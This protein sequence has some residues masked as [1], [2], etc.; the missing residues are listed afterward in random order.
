MAGTRNKQTQLN[1]N[2]YQFELQKQTEWNSPDI[3]QSPAYPC[4]GVNVQR[5]PAKYLATN[6]VDIETYL[7][8][9]GA[10]NYVFPTLSPPLDTKTL[11]AISFTPT[12]N[13]YIPILPPLLQNQR[14]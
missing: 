4:S 13:L 14:P 5:I 7:Y 12:P 6:A 3:L 1:F 8:G 9:I 2:T 10:N 11:P